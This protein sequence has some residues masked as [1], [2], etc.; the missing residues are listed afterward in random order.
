MCSPD[1]LLRQRKGHSFEMATLLGSLLIGH[2]FDAY[3]VSGYATREVTA[4]DQCRVVCPAIAVKES[5]RK[6][7]EEEEQRQ[8]P[9]EVLPRTKYQLKAPIDLGS[10]FLKQLDAE[11]EQRLRE[12]EARTAAEEEERIRVE[13]ALPVDELENKRIHSWVV[14]KLKNG[15][16][17][18]IEPATGFRHEVTDPS[19]LGVESV[20]NHENYMV[21]KQEEIIGRIGEL[22]WDLLD[23]S[24][25]ERLLDVDSDY[26]EVEGYCPK[27]LDMPLSWVNKLSV[28]L[29]AFEERFPGQ[30]KVIKY[31]RAIHEKFAIYKEVDGLVERIRTFETLDYEKPLGMWE[32]FENRADLLKE[33]V[34]DFAGNETMEFFLKGRQR[35]DAL[36][37]SRRVKVDG[38]V[39]QEFEFY[40]KLRFDC[41]KRIEMSAMEIKEFYRGREDR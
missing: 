35:R 4:N 23:R 12:E 20:W 14:V 10:K 27:Y 16:V 15:E 32:Y 21:N 33:R 36:K 5:E 39:V 25:W 28:G 38:D 1:S 31:K 18:F 37:S 6:A 19:Y 9:D 17:F 22:Q 34:T 3:V 26:P 29:K 40:H 7:R 13:E 41:L 30:Q 8:T 24:H 2:G 11:E